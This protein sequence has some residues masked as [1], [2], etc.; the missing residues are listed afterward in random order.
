VSFYDTLLTI[1]QDDQVP[2]ECVAHF[3]NSQASH[4]TQPRFRETVAPLP[5]TPNE[6]SQEE[7]YAL[8][9]NVHSNYN[10]AIY[11]SCSNVD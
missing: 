6:G 9:A 7:V 2:A 1:L 10:F 3:D 8:S 5:S 4:L 11:F